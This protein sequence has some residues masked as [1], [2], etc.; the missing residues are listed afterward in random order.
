MAHNDGYARSSWF[1]RIMLGLSALSFLGFGVA[2]FLDP[3]RIMEMVHINATHPLAIAEIR[4]FY[5]GA[6]IGLAIIMLLALR[7]HV[8]HGLA[9]AGCMYLCIGFARLIGIVMAGS[10]SNFLWFAL[11]TELFLGFGSLLAMRTTPKR[12]YF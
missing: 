6:E 4:A 12:S 7:Y 3:V 11:L 1:A 10:G 9:L 8:K 2:I 5:G